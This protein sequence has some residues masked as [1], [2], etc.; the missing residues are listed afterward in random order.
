MFFFNKPP[1][2]NECKS[3]LS[4]NIYWLDLN[5]NLNVQRCKHSCWTSMVVLTRHQLRTFSWLTS[6]MIITF[7]CSLVALA[8]TTLTWMWLSHARSSKPLEL[9]S[10]HL[11]SNLPVSEQ[12]A[13]R[14]PFRKELVM[15]H[16]RLKNLIH[17]RK[18]SQV[19]LLV[20]SPQEHNTRNLS[21]SP[22]GY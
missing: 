21:R 16:R 5:L 10:H 12:R 20:V 17:E 2:W 4:K 6:M 9:D 1:K 18:E 7:T 11:T 22:R 13:D 14:W 3:F 8:N 15:K 19:F